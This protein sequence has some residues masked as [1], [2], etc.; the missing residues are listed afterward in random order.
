[1]QAR[2]YIRELINKIVQH[3]YKLG[4]F[5]M[6]KVKSDEILDLVEE[7]LKNIELNE[8]LLSNIC[9]KVARIARLMGDI[10]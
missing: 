2:A 1:M 4:V 8:I 9:L 10:E 7:T 6:S 5:N 3:K